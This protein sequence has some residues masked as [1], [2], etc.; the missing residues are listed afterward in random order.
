S[1]NELNGSEE[2]PVESVSNGIN[3]NGS[4]A[5]LSPRGEDTLT[6]ISRPPMPAPTAPPAE[7]EANPSVEDAVV[8]SSAD[9]PRRG[10]WQ[11]LIE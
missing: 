4:E 5:E 11:R 10:W 8:R 3:G 2:S 9:Q 6:K 7:I 1:N